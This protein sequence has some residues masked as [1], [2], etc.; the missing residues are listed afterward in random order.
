[1]KVQRES[2]FRCVFSS[3]S[4]VRVAHIRAWDEEEAIQLF[5]SE[6][7]AEGVGERGTFRVLSPDERLPERSAEEVV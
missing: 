3:R 5:R 4:S 2:V 6:L 7:R 1:M